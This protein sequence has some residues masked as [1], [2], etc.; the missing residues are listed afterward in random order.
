MTETQLRRASPGEAFDPA[1][2]SFPIQT[3]YPIRSKGIMCCGLD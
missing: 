1:F 2:A 3:G